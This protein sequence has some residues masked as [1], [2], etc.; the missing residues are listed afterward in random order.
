MNTH[1]DSNKEIMLDSTVEFPMETELRNFLRSKIIGQ[2]PSTDSITSI[3]TSRMYSLAKR[4]G[5]IAVI[6]LSGPTGVG[7]TETCHALSEYFFG[8]S[9]SFVTINGEDY[10]DYHSSRNLFGSTKS[11]VGYGESTPLNDTSVYKGYNTALDSWTLNKNIANDP[12]LKNFN[13][14]LVDEVEKMHPAVCQNFLGI[15]DKWIFQFPTGKDQNRDAQ[16][17]NITDFSNSIF[18]LTSNIGEYENTKAGIWFHASVEGRSKEGNENVTQAIRKAFSP[19]FIGRI[20]EF[21]CYEPLKRESIENI[22]HIYVNRVA[23]CLQDNYGIKLNSE[24]WV[25]HWLVDMFEEENKMAA[26][27]RGLQKVVQNRFDGVLARIIQSWQLNGFPTW[28]VQIN[29]SYEDHNIHFWAIIKEGPPGGT[30]LVVIEQELR[31]KEMSKYALHMQREAIIQIY[32]RV[33]RTS[34]TSSA[35]DYWPYLNTL[36]RKLIEYGF[37]DADIL[38]LDRVIFERIERESGN[39]ERKRKSITRNEEEIFYP[40]STEEIHSLMLQLWKNQ[41]ESTSKPF[42]KSMVD[43]RLVIIQKAIRDTMMAFFGK[44]IQKDQAIWIGREIHQLY[45]QSKLS[46]K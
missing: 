19:E 25:T 16:H 1:E 17:S 6:Y 30:S 26:G 32:K 21:V 4:T 22:C 34:Y 44:S 45:L 39:T 31:E 5:P 3:I 36:A 28:R 24:D 41:V 14:V 38:D 8:N 29:A 20:T 2:N 27:A 18:I 35:I 11:F 40:F 15:F 10:Q 23:T 12:G 33:S 46:T 7:K 13:I 37:S 43:L 42:K 9:N